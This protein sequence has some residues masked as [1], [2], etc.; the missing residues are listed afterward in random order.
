M[1]TQVVS[2]VGTG[3]ARGGLVERGRVLLA[4]Y[5][6]AISFLRHA[7][8]AHERGDRERFT[9][10]VGRA[11]KV[12]SALSVT[13][14]REQGGE[15]VTMLEQLYEYMQFR[16]QE[17]IRTGAVEPIGDVTSQLGRIYDSYCQVI[18]GLQQAPHGG[19]AAD[20]LR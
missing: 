15:L 17:A 1:K 12:V 20:N 14:D 19:A 10:Y 11:E 13:L 4:L 16:L 5:E 3:D 2:G 6:G 8:S 7:V 9:H 18:E